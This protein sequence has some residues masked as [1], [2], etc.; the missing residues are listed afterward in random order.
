[1]NVKFRIKSGL[2]EIKSTD[3]YMRSF[4]VATEDGECRVNVYSNSRDNTYTVATALK[5]PVQGKNQLYR[6]G[7]TEKEVKEILKN[8]RKH[9]G[10]G[11]RRKK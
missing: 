7:L 9:T 6:K 2:V 1:M 3:P 10:K 8:P 4:M 5:H 11:Y